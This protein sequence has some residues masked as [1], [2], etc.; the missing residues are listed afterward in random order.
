[1]KKISVI[2]MAVLLTLC[3]VRAM[4]SLLSLTGMGSGDN[5]TIPTVS[6]KAGSTFT[7]PVSLENSNTGYVAFQMDI[8]L[9]QGVSPVYDDE[10]YILM[11]KKHGG[12][13]SKNVA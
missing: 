8:Q 6:V 2:I 11:E 9:P 7:V 10:G 5:V 13:H 12:K 3:G 4:A 1:M